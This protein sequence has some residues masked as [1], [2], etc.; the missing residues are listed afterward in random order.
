MPSTDFRLRPSRVEAVATRNEANSRTQ[1]V[2]PAKAN[3]A[4]PIRAPTIAPAT[5]TLPAR[6]PSVA[7]GTFTSVASSS[8][9]GSQTRAAAQ[10]RAVH[11]REAAEH[12]RSGNRH[13]DVVVQPKPHRFDA[14]RCD[15]RQGRGTQ[16]KCQRRQWRHRRPR[17]EAEAS[18]GE[19]ARHHERQRPAYGLVG[20]P[21]Q[22]PAPEPGADDGG[23]AV[24]ERENAPRGGDDV[25]APGE[26]QDQQEHRQR[27]EQDAERVAARRVAGPVEGGAANPREHEQVEEESGNRAQRGLPPRQHAQQQGERRHRDVQRLAPILREACH[28]PPLPG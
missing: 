18:A 10:R 23:R 24:A 9:R 22:R 11:Q 12:N 27:I 3:T 17:P 14:G 8:A 19:P 20:V 2:Q 15:G 21:R 5:V 4:M 13:R 6:H 16:R 26:R 7:M 1:P 25:E 28:A